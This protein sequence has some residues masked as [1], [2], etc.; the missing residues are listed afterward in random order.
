MH[1]RELG[2][3]SPPYC[4]GGMLWS[5]VD[6]WEMEQEQKRI[7]EGDNSLFYGYGYRYT[8]WTSR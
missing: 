8:G 6:G 1:E 5:S 7:L 3:H 2:T 4:A